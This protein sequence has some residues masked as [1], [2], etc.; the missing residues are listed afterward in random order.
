[1]LKA[2]GSG[3]FHTSAMLPAR[4]RLLVA[5]A[6]E[7][8]G[9]LLVV[10]EGV[11]ALLVD[12]DAAGLR[13]AVVLRRLALRSLDLH[14]LGAVLVHL[15]EQVAA[16][17]LLLLP[18][19]VP[20]LP[21]ALHLLVLQADELGVALGLA[22]HIHLERLVGLVR[23]SDR[24]LAVRLLLVLARTALALLLL[25]V[26]ERVHLLALHGPRDLL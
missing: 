10:L 26:H 9:H 11:D 8:L 18:L 3:A 24:A 21:L 20:L 1:M 13:V 12:L 2:A 7:R 15:R 6:H 25:D 14:L 4:E 19:H 23:L 5:L 22:R 17:S 16:G